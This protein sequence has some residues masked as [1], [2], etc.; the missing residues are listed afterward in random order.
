MSSSFSL[1][2]AVSSAR[3][4]EDEFDYDDL[5]AFLAAASL[6][7][8]LPVLTGPSVGAETVADLHLLYPSEVEHLATTREVPLVQAK[9]L[10]M[11]LEKERYQRREREEQWRRAEQYAAQQRV[12]AAAAEE[13]A[14]KEVASSR[15]PQA[16]AY[17]AELAAA[18]P[19]ANPNPRKQQQEERRDYH[20]V[21]VFLQGMVGVVLM[22]F[23][24]SLMLL[25]HSH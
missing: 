22:L 17:Q 10:V 12:A 3:T 21:C 9:K 8:L 25:A 15:A 7:N 6:S 5:P 20:A 16:A 14:A 1:F 24:V 4:K 13:A 11:A 23:G 19:A 18:A 2:S